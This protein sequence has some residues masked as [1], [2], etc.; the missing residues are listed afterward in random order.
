MSPW[1]KQPVVANNA[2]KAIGPY[3]MAVKAGPFLFI[4]G[5][6][7]LDPATG[8]LVSGGIAAETRQALSNLKAILEAAGSS[9]EAVVKTTVFLRDMGEF[10]T[11]NQVY[12]EFFVQNPPARSAI[13]AAALPRGAAVEIEAI[14]LLPDESL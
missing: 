11:M 1:N 7:G 4:S 8:D 2:P 13:Q 14:A 3:S 10:S 5:Q 9:L 6:L 12:N